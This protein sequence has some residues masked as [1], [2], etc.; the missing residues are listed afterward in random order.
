M[1]AEGGTTFATVKRG[2]KAV[3]LDKCWDPV[4]AEGVVGIMLIVM[5]VAA[6]ILLDPRA[7]QAY[8]GPWCALTDIGG[9]TMHENMQHANLGDVRAGGDCGQP[10]LLQ[11]GENERTLMKIFRGKTRKIPHP[12]GSGS[13]I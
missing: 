1:G 11:T 8:E 5:A 10:R 6:A 7:S 4:A 12:R 2:R 3:S 13:L 9:G